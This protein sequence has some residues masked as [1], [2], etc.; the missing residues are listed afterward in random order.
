MTAA[1]RSVSDVA[2]AAAAAVGIRL[3]ELPPPLRLA[4]EPAE[5]NHAA[6]PDS[7]MDMVGQ[8]RV[9]VE[10]AVMLKSA[11]LRGRVPSHVLLYGP[12]GLGKTSLAEIVAH[13]TG[14]KLV[15]ASATAI[16][17]P[18]KLARELAKLERGDVLFIDEIHGL[19]KKTCEVLYTAM[20]DFRIEVESTQAGDKACK[21]QI[22]V[23]QLEQFVLVG[24]TT[25]PGRLP[26]PLLDR[27]GFKGALVHYS[28]G[29][30][31]QII[32]RKAESDGVAIEDEAAVELGGRSRGTPRI[33]LQLLDACQDYAVTTTEDPSAPITVD[34][35]AATLALKDI[36]SAGLTMTDQ[37]V[38]MSLCVDHMGGPVG[39]NNLAASSGE[40]MHTVRDICE[41][42]LLRAGFIKR[43]TRGRVA[44]AAAY[45]HLGLKVPVGLGI[46]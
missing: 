42:W 45:Q 1:L 19:S 43:T 5:P 37:L 12:P 28:G 16:Q 10:L 46:L 31:A 7:V 40:E 36:D 11:R 34:V 17:S 44:T 30:L 2:S 6:R 21:G 22:E 8:E 27:F 24:A 26:Q 20:E 35:V 3:T 29:E 9:R 38:L 4:P 13:E 33:A 14:G 23:V 15:R 32:T 18:M 41:P 25:D 39:V